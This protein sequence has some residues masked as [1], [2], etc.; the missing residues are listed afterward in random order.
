[1]RKT[2]VLGLAGLVL[3]AAA[4]PG[5]ADDDDHERARAALERGEA[6]PLRAVLDRAVAD[7]PGR[8]LEVELE[9]EDGRLV[10]EVEL[11]AEGGRVVELVY[12]ART[13]ALLEAEGAGLERL[14]RPRDRNH[15]RED[16]RE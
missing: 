4:V 2:A 13:G 16:G 3:A 5:R 7:V 12:D 9:E 10:Y 15:D 8:L 14:L 11:L 6:L 1:M